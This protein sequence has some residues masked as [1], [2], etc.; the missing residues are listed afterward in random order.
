ML[1]TLSPCNLVTLSPAHHYNT[2]MR[3]ILS[4][5]NAD[6]DAVASQLAASK[7]TPDGIMLLA[8]RQ[9]RNVEQFLTLYWDAFRFVRPSEWRKQRVKE[10]LLVDTQ[11]LNSVRG[12]VA[13][14]AVHVIDHHTEQTPPAAWTAQVEPV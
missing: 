13:K 11:S 12:M 3:L 14:P 2:P 10:V 9:N 4:H 1:S 6:F 7:L 5:E 8:R